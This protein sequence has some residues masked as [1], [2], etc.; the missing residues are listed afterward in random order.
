MQRVF[1]TIG[2]LVLLFA[3]LGGV[4]FFGHAPETIVPKEEALV[5]WRDGPPDLVSRDA[6]EIFKKA[7]WRKPS[8]ED[9]ILHAERHEWSD[10]EGVSRWQWF[11]V[12]EA[13]PDLIKY[14]RDDNAFGL[15]PGRADPISEAP[16]WFTFNPADVSVLKAPHS[17]M[18][19]MFSKSG[20]S[21]YAKANG[22][23]FSKGA[24]APLS[25]PSFSTSPA[26]APGR[27]PD[28]PPPNR[29]K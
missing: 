15:I 16:A 4:W 11:L 8:P 5:V 19:L 27:L 10:D 7:L 9:E 22:L 14:L 6:E 23:G 2:A 25:T 20:N 24:P 26:P 17:G 1:L 29:R 13:S 18:Q 21:V 3:S 12:I 28:F